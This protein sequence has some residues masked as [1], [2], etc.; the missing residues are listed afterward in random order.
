MFQKIISLDSYYLI[1]LNL[2]VYENRFNYED[3]KNYENFV[4]NSEFAEIYCEDKNILKKIYNNL[5]L[6]K[7]QNI[8][9]INK[10]RNKFSTYGD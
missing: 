4:N 10:V 8:K 2:Q 3:I 1:F 9:I 5:L 6:N 7:F